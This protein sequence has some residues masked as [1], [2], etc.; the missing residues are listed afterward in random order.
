M[1]AD[2][3]IDS[4]TQ[5]QAIMVMKAL[6]EQIRAVV[7]HHLRNPLTLIISVAQLQGLKDVEAEAKHIIEDLKMFGL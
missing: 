1:G 4:K 7:A 2:N 6:P 5:K 3:A